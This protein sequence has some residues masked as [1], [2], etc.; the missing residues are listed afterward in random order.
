M[1]AAWS[2]LRGLTVDNPLLRR[3]R[4]DIGVV[5]HPRSLEL[6]GRIVDVYSWFICRDLV[7]R[8]EQIVIFERPFLG[9]YQKRHELPKTRIGIIE[10]LGLILPRLL[11]GNIGKDDKAFITELQREIERRIGVKLELGNLLAVQLRRFKVRARLY[12]HLL[13]RFPVKKLYVV[14]AYFMAPLID[15]CRNRG[16]PVYEIQHGVIGKY[17]LGYSFPGRPPGTLRYFPDYLLAWGEGWPNTKHLPL[18]PD[19]CIQYGFRYFDL[20]TGAYPRDR[21]DPGRVLIISQSVHGNE[22]AKFLREHLDRFKGWRIT[23]KLHPSEFNRRGEY[24]DLRFLEEHV[25]HFEVIESGDVHELLS[26]CSAVIGVFSTVLFEA[27]AFNCEVYVCPLHGWEYME[28][29]LEE[30]RVKPFAVFPAQAGAG[31]PA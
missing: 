1:S 7:E 20:N 22:L 14:V 5:D 29:L 18:A 15:V 23:Y 21:Q 11:P 3:Q 25:E 28:E 31:K 13:D 6:E 30:E 17:H 2:F 4:A 12:E 27:L 10:S 8:G 24:T 9:V 16:I 19:R 26:N